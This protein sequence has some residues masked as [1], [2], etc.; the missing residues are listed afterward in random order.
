MTEIEIYSTPACAY[1]ERA[2]TFFRSKGLAYKE[3][4][5]SKN[6]QKRQE[7]FAATQSLAVPVIN[8]R[9]KFL[10]GFNRQKI[11]ELLNST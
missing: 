1:C 4:D 7:M 9:G 2:K 8:V 6:L 5:I 11:E 10:V 3:H